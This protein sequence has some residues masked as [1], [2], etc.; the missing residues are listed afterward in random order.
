MYW[1][2]NEF[3]SCHRQYVPKRQRYAHWA[4][5]GTSEHAHAFYNGLI[6]RST[7]CG[8]RTHVLIWKRV[9]DIQWVA[10]QLEQRDLSLTITDSPTYGSIPTLIC[11]DTNN[12]LPYIMT[13]ADD[14]KKEFFLSL[15]ELLRKNVKLSHNCFQ[16][17]ENL[18]SYFVYS[19]ATSWAK[20]ST[21]IH[22]TIFLNKLSPQSIIKLLN[23]SAVN[24]FSQLHPSPFSQFKLSNFTIKYLHH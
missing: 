6:K 1:A 7:Y 15:L 14:F 22:H 5:Y 11:F 24:S 19:L 9:I 17:Y 18:K 4:Y 10:Y 16:T 8:I 3:L 13:S 21:L 12:P 20:D 23:P 2:L